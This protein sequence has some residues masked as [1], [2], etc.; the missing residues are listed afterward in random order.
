MM[1]EILFR[2]KHTDDGHW[3]YGAYCP[4]D[5]QCDFPCILPPYYSFDA[6]LPHF[7]VNDKT[8]GQYTGIDDENDEKIFDGDVLKFR[9]GAL[10]TERKAIIEYANGAFQA[11]LS[12]TEVMPLSV[13]YAYCSGMVE[14][15]GN[16]HD[17]PELLEKILD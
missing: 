13:L 8:V 11:R 1:R 10:K 16:V 17:N 5:H 2:G 6:N 15:I 9:V 4:V 14:I 3:L 7:G 12:K